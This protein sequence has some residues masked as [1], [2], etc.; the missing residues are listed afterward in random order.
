MRKIDINRRYRNMAIYCA[1]WGRKNEGKALI[2]WNQ[3]RS[4][5]GESWETYVHELNVKGMLHYGS[6]YVYLTPAWAA[7]TAVEQMK[8]IQEMYPRI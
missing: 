2:T 6:G 1:T 3:L 4:H 8:A 5:F 7:M